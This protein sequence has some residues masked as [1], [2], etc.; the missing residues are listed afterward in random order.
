MWTLKLEERLGYNYTISFLSG[1]V[2]SPCSIVR[3]AIL[4]LSAV[5]LRYI[6]RFVAWFT[7]YDMVVQVCVPLVLTTRDHLPRVWLF[8]RRL[9]VDTRLF[10]L[11]N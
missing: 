2:A 3:L 7:C 9:L 8:S 10:M 11:L 1:L 4:R 6:G 5:I